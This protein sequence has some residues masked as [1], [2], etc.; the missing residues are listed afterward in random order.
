MIFVYAIA[1]VMTGSPRW[2]FFIRPENNTV[3]VNLTMVEGATRADTLEQLMMAE[4]YVPELIRD[5]RTN[6][7]SNMQRELGDMGEGAWYSWPKR[8]YDQRVLPPR[9]SALKSG[10]RPSPEDD[11]VVIFS[12]VGARSGFGFGGR[13]G[14]RSRPAGQCPGRAGRAGHP[15]LRHPLAVLRPA[16][17]P[18]TPQA[19]RP[20][21][22]P[23]LWRGDASS[24]SVALVGGETE[25]L[26][27]QPC[28]F[29]PSSTGI[30][31][32]LKPRTTRPMAPRSWLRR[33][34][35]R[36]GAGL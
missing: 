2:S 12:Q 25:Q 35:P 13:L 29:Q 32:S 17:D 3:N 5:A 14:C 16:V 6:H 8:Q 21:F 24:I 18:Q 1:M 30:Q 27:P 11:V 23:V 4:A 9:S 22:A 10:S 26:R 20:R 15:D 33:S 28:S 7:L 31:G 19:R 36:R 34:R